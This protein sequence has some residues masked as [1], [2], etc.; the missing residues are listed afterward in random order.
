MIEYSVVKKYQ[1]N[2]KE[3]K[4]NNRF[5]DCHVHPFD[6]I[7]S[8]LNYKPNLTNPDIY[9]LDD[10]AVYESPDFSSISL[11]NNATDSE[12]TNMAFVKRLIEMKSK[13][14][15]KHIGPKVMTDHMDMCS[16]DESLLLQVP[17]GDE[18]INIEMELMVK[19]FGGNTRFKMSGSL[20][21]YVDNKNII[22]Y[23]NSMS[24]KY[25][26]E[27]F[28]LHPIIT[29]INLATD[30][31]KERI[32]NVLLACKQNK[33]PIVI[34]GGTSFLFKDQPEGAYTEIENIE[35]I[36]WSISENTVVIAHA[37]SYDCEFDSV[38]KT[39]LPKLIKI[40]EQHNNLM[41]DISA[42]SYRTLTLVLKK[43][44]ITRIIFGSDAL[45]YNQSSAVITL[46]HLLK[47]NIS[48]PIE[49][50]IKIIA[51]NPSQTVFKKHH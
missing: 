15:Y 32:E 3:I 29:G 4:M 18:D 27:A 8:G 43:I 22:E 13:K 24:N 41:I 50:F 14:I 39:I 10:S 1:E 19:M 46:F 45:Y 25:A 33:L 35:R 23:I 20:P 36:N 7:L 47:E 11:K 51:I 12:I 28:K 9:S 16:I 17:I 30:F 49:K 34:H 48:S 21:N 6:I 26:I 42:L 2:I 38:E 5:Y 40:L 37:A 31:G 44:D